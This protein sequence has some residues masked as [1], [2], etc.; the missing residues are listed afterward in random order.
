MIKDDSMAA[1]L[2][3][4]ITER[5]V[6]TDTHFSLRI[7]CDRPDF[8]AGQF[9]RV[10]L[11]VDGER[12]ARP[13]SCVN[14]PDMDGFEIF[15]NIV[16]AG[17][18]SGPLSTLQVGDIL[19]VSDRCNGLLTLQ[20]IP[21][22]ARDLW[23]VATGTG[24]GPFLSVLRTAETWQRFDQVVLAY[25]VREASQLAYPAVIDQL[26]QEHANLHFMP[27]VT[28]QPPESVYAGR[29]TQALADGQLEAKTGVTISTDSHFMLCGNMAMI[30]DMTEALKQRGLKKHLRREPGHISSEKYH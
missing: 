24:V 1:W 18:L 30:R 21:A 17:P 26:C 15:F 22:T 12:I 5:T 2:E 27:C 9:I 14:S 7:A 11:D 10:A 28:Q 8:I 4:R 6:W 13:Y 16:P 29:I 25:G 20:E 3:G 23:L 19:W